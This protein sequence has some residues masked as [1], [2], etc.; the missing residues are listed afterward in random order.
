[1]HFPHLER[2][3]VPCVFERYQ[4]GKLHP[5]GR[6]YL[7]LIILR[8]PA[9]TGAAGTRPEFWL[10]IVDRHH[11]VAPQLAGRQGQARLIAALGSLACPAAGAA[12]GLYAERVLAPGYASTMPN[13]Q[14][15]IEDVLNWEQ[16]QSALAQATFYA[17]LLV[18]IGYGTIGLRSSAT[19]ASLEAS[20]GKSRLSA[21]DCLLLRRARLDIL[22]FVATVE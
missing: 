1:M 10:S 16:Q 6:R 19:T 21:G 18:D 5:D 14:G 7:P 17:E 12:R 4:A 3:S 11:R 20:F 22:A 2:L 15:C 9:S 8:L 13:L